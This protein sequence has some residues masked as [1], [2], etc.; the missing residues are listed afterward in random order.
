MKIAYAALLAMALPLA[1][2]AQDYQYGYTEQQVKTTD[3]DGNVSQTTLKQ[4]WAAESAPVT[5]T[6][7]DVNAP[8]DAQPAAADTPAATDETGGQHSADWYKSKL[9]PGE[10]YV[11]N[12]ATGKLE[13]ATDNKTIQELNA[14]AL[15]KKTAE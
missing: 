7:T 11:F 6:M 3:S 14:K 10:R 12:P 15:Q 13:A 2:H 1:A 9:Q 4:T 5:G 8:A